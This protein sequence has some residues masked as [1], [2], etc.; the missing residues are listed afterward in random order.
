MTGGR[1][2]VRELDAMAS[3][4]QIRVI[5]LRID[6]PGG[7]VLASDQ[8]WRAVRRAREKKPVIASMG[9]V[10]TSGGYYVACAA[11]EIWA[12][13]STITGSI[14]IFYGKV[15]VA[16]LAGKLGVTIEHF[17]RGRRAG[18][19]SL[20]RPFTA[21]ERAALTQ[22]LRDYYQRFLERVAVG[23]AM[24]VADVDAL[25]RGQVFAGEQARANGLIDRLGG[26][27]AVLARARHLAEL[28]ADAGVVVR[29]ER[30][31]G[32]LDFIL[33]GGL[34]AED[35]TAQL[36]APRQAVVPLP[37]A[38]RPLLKALALMAQMGS[39]E[40]LALLPYVVDY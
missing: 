23:R 36:L 32:L 21:D 37:D 8:I 25:G 14:G 39:G 31:G 30:A 18:G 7:A 6:S 27:G 28:P 13:A 17:R 20:F 38:V 22:A 2:I 15:D 10:A 16:E 24:S 5:V 11:D 34:R 12:D 3:D 19:E 29:P 9:S 40:P 35:D 33:G 1:T 4:P 26:L